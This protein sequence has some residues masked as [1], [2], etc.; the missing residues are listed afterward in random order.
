MKESGERETERTENRKKRGER[1]ATK[2]CVCDADVER[3][4]DCYAMLSNALIRQNRQI[5]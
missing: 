2:E 3:Q 5:D 1:K 4:R